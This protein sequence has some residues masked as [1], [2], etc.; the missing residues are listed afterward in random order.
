MKCCAKCHEHKPLDDFYRQRSRK[1]GRHSYCKQ[2]YNARKVN[3]KPTPTALRR[4]RN[5][6]NKY[7]LSTQQ[8]EQMLRDQGGVCAICR[9][10]PKRPCVDHDHLTGRVRAI[11]CHRCNIF[12]PAIEDRAFAEAAAAYLSA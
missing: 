4:E 1:D 6:L 9:L 5:F 10:S 2:C 7:G 8:V 3:R 12:L 11:L